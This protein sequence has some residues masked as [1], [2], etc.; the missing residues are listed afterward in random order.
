MVPNCTAITGSIAVIFPFIYLFFIP[1]YYTKPNLR[2]YV[3]H[4]STKLSSYRK[5]SVAKEEAIR[6]KWPARY[7]HMPDK[8]AELQASQKELFATKTDYGSVCVK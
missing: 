5:I 7:G 4:I 1:H 6:L 3:M 2:S 8:Y